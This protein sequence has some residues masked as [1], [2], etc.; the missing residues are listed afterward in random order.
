MSKFTVSSNIFTCRGTD[1]HKDSHNSSMTYTIY[2]SQLKFSLNQIIYH[3]Q[4]TSKLKIMHCKHAVES[5]AYRNHC[6]NTY[7]CIEASN[8]K[9][10]PCAGYPLSTKSK[11]PEPE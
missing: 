6:Y 11:K 1:P 10:C 3:R 9:L 2:H 8:R 7:L 4:L 5:N